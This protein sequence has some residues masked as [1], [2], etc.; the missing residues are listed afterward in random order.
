VQRRDHR[1]KPFFVAAGTACAALG[2]SLAASG[3]E[4]SNLASISTTFSHDCA[5]TTAGGVKCW[6]FGYLGDGIS[7]RPFAN[8]S[9]PLDV[10]GLES[11]V[12]AVTT[13]AET[14]CAITGAGGVKCWGPNSFG[15]VG[16]GTAGTQRPSPTDVV[17]LASGVVQVAIGGAHTCALMAGGT[18]KCWGDNAAGDLGDGTSTMRPTPVDVVGIAD[19]VSIA[20]SG[21]ESCALSSAGGVKC[22]GFLSG[23]HPVDVAGVTS[24]VT[25]IYG[26]S[27]H[28][29]ATMAAGGVRCWGRNDRGELGDG[30]T[31]R[32]AAA[33]DVVGLS[34]Q[35]T[36][37]ALGN[38]STCALLASGAVECW[39]DNGGGQLGDGF[40]SIS[41]TRPTETLAFT[42]GVAAI[43]MDGPRACA[44]RAGRARCWGI[45]VLNAGRSEDQAF[46]RPIA[47]GVG[48]VA[49]VQTIVFDPLAPHDLGDSPFTVA[50]SSSA[51]LP[52]QFESLS[53][54]VCSVS[55]S[56]VTLNAPGICTIA[57]LQPGDATFDA[58]V[59]VTRS[60]L[61]T[62]A[63]AAVAPRLGNIST[64]ALVGAD[65]D[66]VIAGF[67]IGGTQPKTVLVTVAGPS[68]ATAGVAGPLPDPWIRL[69]R[70][71][72]GATLATNH[73]WAVADFAIPMTS[74]R[75]REIGFAPAAAAEPALMMNLEPGAYTVVVSASPGSA[76]GVGVVGV[77][78]L[79]HPE[80][81]LVNISTR[82][83]VLTGDDVMIGGFIITGTAPQ[84]VVITGTGPSLVGAGIPNALP[85]P[86]LTL[87]RASDQGVIATND[88]WGT[89]ANASDIQAAGFAPA[90]A[91][92]SAIMVTLPPGA[93]T[94]ILAGAGG[95]S[96]VGIVA[97]YAVR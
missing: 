63:P 65:N 86:T 4:L 19:A 96:G 82:G 10:P 73:D 46:P 14:T 39:G 15:Q 22:W 31:T 32:R 62:G 29:C 95:S 7:A 13:R 97:V 36:A 30:T 68:L 80:T 72:D 6:G 37:M 67:V 51:G 58:A 5:L 75:T 16:D 56:S 42:A 92:E 1:S 47:E 66:V 3:A 18:V 64:R 20:L 85:D 24:G 89:A 12:L 88:D 44:L 40:L 57:A 38:E 50:A 23:L 78:E 53:E 25:A 35:V 55:G 61:V 27:D 76:L 71:S 9:P 41:R 54:R 93:Y 21:A 17:G 91:K 90:N 70:S 79:D 84:T 26:G 8:T 69:V 33:A 59:H 94:A 52:V 28:L 87:V 43:S 2:I 60:F 34:G 74:V 77:F 83:Q 49:G 11:G 45:D 81:P 48:G